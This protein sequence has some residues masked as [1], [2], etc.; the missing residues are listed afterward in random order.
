[1]NKSLKSVKRIMTGM[2][3]VDPR[4]T[5]NL[6]VLAHLDGNVVEAR[7][8]YEN[9]LVNT[10]SVEPSLRESL[11]TT[12]LYNL[13]RAYEDQGERSMARDA[14]E[15]LLSRHPEYVDGECLVY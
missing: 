1:M 14:Y 6:G 10:A 12:M 2:G 4:I 11:E 9:A 7:Q 5:N 3:R 15:K 8:L 13:A